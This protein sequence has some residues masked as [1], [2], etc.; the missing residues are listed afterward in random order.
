MG[1][2]IAPQYRPARGPTGASLEARTMGRRIAFWVVLIPFLA[3]LVG[4]V[5]LLRSAVCRVEFS[6]LLGMYWVSHLGAGRVVDR[7]FSHRSSQ[8]PRTIRATLAIMGS[9]ATQGPVM[10]WA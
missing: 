4:V 10:Q 7:S 9:M 6:L 3:R 8:T 1:S 2:I 5:L